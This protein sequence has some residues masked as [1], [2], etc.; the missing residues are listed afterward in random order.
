MG[1]QFLPWRRSAVYDLAD[2]ASVG[3]PR[4]TAKLQL[5][6]ADLDDPGQVRDGRS[7]F[8][9]LGPGDVAGLL[10]GAVTARVPG[11]GTPD[12]EQTKSVQMEF[13]APDLPW[14]YS[15][16]VPEAADGLRPWLV[17]VVGTPE[18]V[19]VGADGTV[20]LTGQVLTEH[21]LADSYRWAHVHDHD[22]RPVARLL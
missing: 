7:P 11:P 2:P 8:Q 13:A 16:C 10:A 12:A 4:L 9:I 6:L 5:R 14:R 17:L 1:E 19:V 18:E 15:P 22:N 21:R 3:Q 20:R